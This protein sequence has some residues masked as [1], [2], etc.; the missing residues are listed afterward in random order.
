MDGYDLSMLDKS[1]LGEALVRLRGHRSQRQ[2]AKRAGVPTGTWCQWE[3]G[4]RQPRDSQ[5]EKILIGLGCSFDDLTLTIWRIQTERFK[6]RGSEVK[7]FA[8]P[9]GEG[10]ILK[11]AEG[12]LDIDLDR[13]P[14]DARPALR[15][16]RQV[17]KALCTQVE[18]LLSEYEALVLALSRDQRFRR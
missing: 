13:M 1:L 18:P 15:R 3:K 9:Q 6:L 10:D 7:S 8:K 11:R 12:L 14:E 16:M 4:K 17:I 2:V 5:I